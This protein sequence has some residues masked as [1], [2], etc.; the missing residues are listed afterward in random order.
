MG[1][2]T[3]GCPTRCP[4]GTLIPYWDD[5]VVDTEVQDFVLDMDWNSGQDDEPSE[6]SDGAR[7][8]PENA[9]LLE[10]HSTSSLGF[11]DISM[12]LDLDSDENIVDILET[13]SLDDPNASIH[14]PFS[15]CRPVPSSS[16]DICYLSPGDSDM[17]D[18]HEAGSSAGSHDTPSTFM[19]IETLC[20]SNSTLCSTTDQVAS[21]TNMLYLGN[22][23]AEGGNIPLTADPASQ[24]SSQ[25]S[26]ALSAAPHDQVSL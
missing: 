23:S 22:V 24:G 4:S 18:E 1:T 25:R 3:D 16:P 14:T 6:E 12:N 10:Q 20:R 15:S 17:F 26:T 7:S 9:T 2:H 19:H 21:A 11:S 8:H 5:H 13:Q